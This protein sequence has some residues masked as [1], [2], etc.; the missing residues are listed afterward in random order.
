MPKF[1]LESILIAFAA[2]VVV[3]AIVAMVLRL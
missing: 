3:V 2:T 1:P